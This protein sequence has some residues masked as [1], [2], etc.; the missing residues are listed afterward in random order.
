M[1]QEE[2]NV[3][4]CNVFE[5]DEA[6][7]TEKYTGKSGRRVRGAIRGIEEMDPE[8]KRSQS[9]KISASWSD[10]PDRGSNISKAQ[11]NMSYEAKKRL[12]QKEQR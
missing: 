5:G 12:N 10:T 11:M 8:T 3:P 2:D 4:V 6:F 7:W 1:G 9:K